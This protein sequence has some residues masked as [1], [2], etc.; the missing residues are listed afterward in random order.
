[1]NGCRKTATSNCSH[2]TDAWRI[3]WRS[4]NPCTAQKRDIKGAW[5]GEWAHTISCA[6]G[7]AGGLGALGLHGAV[8]L[9]SRLRALGCGTVGLPSCLGALTLDCGT[10]ALANCLGALST[11]G[12]GA[13]TLPGANHGSSSGGGV[14][15]GGRDWAIGGAVGN[16]LGCGAGLDDGKGKALVGGAHSVL[17]ARVEADLGDDVRRLLAADLDNDWLRRA[18]ARLEAGWAA[19]LSAVQQPHAPISTYFEPLPACMH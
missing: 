7:L 5:D 11:L 16:A 13:H 12:G 19:D 17:V 4:S 15:V 9:A 6:A 14:G 8:A 1:M 18:S 2:I 3:Q 10:V